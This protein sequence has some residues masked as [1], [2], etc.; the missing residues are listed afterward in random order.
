MALILILAA[1][2]LCVAVLLWS[3]LW[4]FAEAPVLQNLREA[5]DS[6]VQVRAFHR[7]Y[8]PFPGCILEGVVFYHGSGVGKPLITIEKLTIR[9]TYLGLLSKHAGRITA[10]SMRVF[11]PAF[12][13]GEAFHTTPSKI[14]ID[15]IVA[16]GASVE[17]ASRNADKQPL[18]FD[19]HEASL[20]DVGWKGPLTYHLKVRNPEPPGEVTTSGKFGV[21]NKSDPGQTPISGEYKF[22]QADL[23]VYQGIAGQ[24]SSTGKFGGTLGHIDISGTTNT[25]DFEVKSGKHPV[26]LITERLRRRHQ[27]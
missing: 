27:R 22:E 13:T 9:G 8:F 20:R 24:L 14:T 7:T 17:F 19:V 12:G 25:P 18:R 6:Q 10:E 2:T 15:E 1:A 16:N 3:R 11:V 5:S 4:P 23:G 26:K 21:W